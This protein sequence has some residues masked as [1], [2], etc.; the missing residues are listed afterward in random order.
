MRKKFLTKVGILLAV[1]CIFSSITAVASDDN[2]Y[3]NFTIKIHQKNSTTGYRYRSTKYVEN[4]WKVK[5]EYTTE[6][7]G[8]ITTFWLEGSYG[9]NV[10]P[11]V[12]A[13]TGRTYYSNPYKSANQ[14]NVCLAAENNTYENYYYYCTGNWDEETWD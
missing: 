10:S 6:G 12:Y 2:Y 3:Y 5:I 7:V 11:D 13:T 1:M 9:K 14:S 8:S 4:P